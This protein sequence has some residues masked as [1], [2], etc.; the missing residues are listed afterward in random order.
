MPFSEGST[1]STIFWFFVVP[2]VLLIG[3]IVLPQRNRQKKQKEFIESL[4][5][6]DKVVTYSGIIG[7]IEKIGKRTVILRVDEKTR[8]EFLKE[9][10]TKLAKDL[11]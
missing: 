5:V 4:K 3:I 7:V 6:K 10:I 1:L 9:A 2:F 11:D 8:M